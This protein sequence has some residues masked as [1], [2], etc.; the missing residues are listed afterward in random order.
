MHEQ[1]NGFLWP[2]GVI[3]CCPETALAL[4][5]VRT[6]GVVGAP[7]VRSGG[8]R[9]IAFVVPRAGETVNEAAI[10]AHCVLR[11][12]SYKC[13]AEVRWSSNCR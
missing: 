7:D 4:G 11:L 6:V 8:E 5:T 12:V 10:S 9:V 2:V 3:D 1:G 13:P